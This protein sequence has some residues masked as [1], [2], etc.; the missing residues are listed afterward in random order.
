M[1]N[2]P[3]YVHVKGRPLNESDEDS[4]NN[5]E[6]P[7]FNIVSNTTL[8][9]NDKTFEFN[10]VFTSPSEFRATINNDNNNNNENDTSTCYLFMGPTNS[11]KTTTLYQLLQHKLHL[12]T[13][14]KTICFMTA[15]E[16]TDNRYILDLLN[17]NNDNAARLNHFNF[18]NQLIKEKLE[19]KSQLS[20]VFGKRL[21][22]RTVF[23]QKSSRSVLIITLYYNNLRTTYID[24]MG[25][26]QF[27][28]NDGNVTPN[29]QINTNTF[30]NANISS[31]MQLVLGG[32]SSATTMVGRSS[33]LITN[34]IFK[35]SP[36]ALKIILNLDPYGD[37]KLIRSTLNNIVSLI[38]RFATLNS[39]ER[40]SQTTTSSS[41]TNRKRNLPHYAQP[42]LSSLSPTKKKIRH[43]FVITKPV[44]K[45]FDN[46]ASK[47]ALDA[48]RDQIS[49]IVDSLPINSE[50]NTEE[51]SPI[52]LLKFKAET[53][54]ALNV[55]HE[56]DKN[57]LK[58]E[59]DSLIERNDGNTDIMKNLQRNLD[60]VNG[61]LNNNQIELAQRQ[62]KITELE[63]E[64]TENKLKIE[65]AERDL[66]EK[67]DSITQL[68]HEL[69]ST[70][71]KLESEIAA[72]KSKV[73]TLESESET[74]TKQINELKSELI[75]KND[76]VGKL[77]SELN[78]INSQVSGLESE[79]NSRTQQ[80]NELQ[81][82]L[83]KRS[84]QT[85]ELKQ[86]VTQLNN[87]KSQTEQQL[88]DAK[89]KLSNLENNSSSTTQELD[90]LNNSVTNLTNKNQLVS[91]ELAETK[92]KLT[93]M[94]SEL[95]EKANRISQLDSEVVS[96]QQAKTKLEDKLT[97]LKSQ[98]EHDISLKDSRIAELSQQTMSEQTQYKRLES[99]YFELK[100]SFET[101]ENQLNLQVRQ[102]QD[103]INDKD[104]EISKLQAQLNQY[105]ETSAD[106]QTQKEVSLMDVPLI[107]SDNLMMHF[108]SLKPSSTGLSFDPTNDI[109]QDKENTPSM[110]NESESRSVSSS[111][112]L[113]SSP[114][115]SKNNHRHNHDNILTTNNNINNYKSM[116]G[117]HLKK[118]KSGNKKSPSKSPKVNT[119]NFGTLLNQH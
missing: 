109:F 17:S 13:E 64:I 97:T 66:K 81:T 42:T 37:E 49:S 34:L 35:K 99:Q 22:K 43:N 1:S 116:V 5:D 87:I 47:K 65:N 45:L 20:T 68:H 112:A 28:T 67:E 29:S 100:S 55:Q 92:S 102:L 104:I 38:H 73:S 74:K 14:S 88:Q 51:I 4:L 31:I 70:L 106:N 82:D 26:E 41:N 72:Y 27:S 71:T 98:F 36:H 6:V 93:S 18:E 76:H 11:G 12:L 50:T 107:N 2:I 101:T 8:E 91:N 15:F 83:D 10:Q 33:N 19:Y 3:L 24:L 96:L 62:G 59:I 52:E 44:S 94:K 39:N 25:N 46:S 108:P 118:K 105:Q 61:E 117:K 57:R 77:Q 53:L 48:L 95:I 7:K 78:K 111:P 90:Q 69:T 103:S 75:N 16:I 30:A 119:N 54:V 85:I 9:V 89:N 32:K 58:V 84:N 63:K 56:A 60:F 80:V 40:Q 114:T 23:N 110:V 21:T 86:K 79:L 113:A 115:K